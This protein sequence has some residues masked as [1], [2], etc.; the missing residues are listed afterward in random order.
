MFFLFFFQL[1]LEDSKLFKQEIIKVTSSF[2]N[3][4]KACNIIFNVILFFHSLYFLDHLRLSF[5]QHRMLLYRSHVSSHKLFLLFNNSFCFI[6]K[7]QIEQL[8][9]H[10]FPF[11]CLS[12]IVKILFFKFL[13]IRISKVIVNLVL[14]R[15]STWGNRSSIYNVCNWPLLHN[16]GSSISK[17]ISS[18]NYSYVSLRHLSWRYLTFNN[19]FRLTSSFNFWHRMYRF[20]IILHL[21]S[22]WRFIDRR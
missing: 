3:Q 7:A 9:C 5:N 15:R 6:D 12:Q 13:L 4:L 16:Q 11:H 21:Q 20:K 2:E 17:W 8:F 18:G 14:V 19:R 1:S 10:I 22:Y